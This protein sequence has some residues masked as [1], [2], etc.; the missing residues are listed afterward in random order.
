MRDRQDVVRT[1]SSRQN[2]LVRNFRD[3]A[4]DPDPTGER[5]LLDGA[6]LVRDALS[7]GAEFEVL[8]VSTSRADEGEA[9]ALARELALAG[10][11]VVQVADSVFPALTPVK[12]SSGIAAIARRRVS[13]PAMICSHPAAFIVAACDV[14]DPGNVGSLLRSAEAGGGTG[15]F[16]CGASA[17]PFSWKAL[18]GSMGSALRLPIVAGMT[19]SA[20]LSC[21]RD[22]DVRIIAAVP[23]DGEP[24]DEIDWRG[25]VG[26]FAG[27]EG[28]GLDPEII[29]LADARVTIPMAA[30]VESLNVAVAAGILVYAARRQ[31]S[32][33]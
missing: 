1:I 11:D 27:G 2:P 31:R 15:A 29:A 13:T 30:S 25:R 5:V 21:M 3:L 24:P 23:R 22:A 12:T 14:Q 16:V 6:H 10:V 18:R 28:S 9:A 8:A 4:A 20:V 17:N 26:L 33:L 7:A 32:A 19:A